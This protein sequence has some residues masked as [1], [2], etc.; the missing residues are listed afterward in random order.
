M[1]AF[2]QLVHL[3]NARGI[4]GPKDQ[5]TT[6][7][8]RLVYYSFQEKRT[9]YVLGATQ[10]STDAGRRAEGEGGAVGES[11]YCGFC[12]KELIRLSVQA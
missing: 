1:G 2:L 12:E 4:V 8:E 9:L 10:G 11:L 6:D 7:I 5:E 3:Q